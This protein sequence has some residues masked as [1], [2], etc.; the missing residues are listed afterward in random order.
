MA[1][2]V[3]VLGKSGSGKSTSVKTLDPKTTIIINVL[4]KRLPFKGSTGIYNEENHNLL[5]LSNWE[6][7]DAFLNAVSTN[8]NFS[9][10]KN[11]VI[12]D[13]IYVMRKEFFHRA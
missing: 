3:M 8:E 13:F 4:N 10:V 11:V 12:D 1:N 6:E 2:I 9:Y 5:Q 7:V